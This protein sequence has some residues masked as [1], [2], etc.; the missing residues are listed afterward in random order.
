M[1]NQPAIGQILPFSS[2]LFGASQRR[3]VA[4]TLLDPTFRRY[5]IGFFNQL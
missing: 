4:I 1:D 3:G 5:S 2:T